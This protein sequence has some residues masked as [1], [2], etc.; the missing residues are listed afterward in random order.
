LQTFAICLA[1]TE[2]LNAIIW[3][4]FMFGQS[5]GLLQLS[6]KVEDFC[7]ISPSSFQFVIEVQICNFQTGKSE[8]NFK[9]I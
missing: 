2:T 5:I 9:W 8:Q 1:S 7:W 3:Y 4:F 6:L